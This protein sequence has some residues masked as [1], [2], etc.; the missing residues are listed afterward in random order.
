MDD[1]RASNGRWHPNPPAIVVPVIFM[2]SHS[3]V[4]GGF[5]VDTSWDDGMQGSVGMCEH[6]RLY[7]E[8]E[9]KAAAS[10]AA[11]E[12]EIPW[13]GAWCRNNDACF[14]TEASVYDLRAVPE[15]REV[16]QMHDV[17]VRPV[18]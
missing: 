5:W 3:L 15:P 6:Y 11:R 8:E 1:C 9:L 18:Y 10:K 7:S 14:M 12:G 4:T 16:A 17:E 13:R 2:T